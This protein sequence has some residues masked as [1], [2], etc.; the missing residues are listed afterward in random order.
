[1]SEGVVVTLGGSRELSPMQRGLWASQL[2]TPGAPVQN[3]VLVSHIDGPVDPERLA[4]AFRTVVEASDVLRTRLDRATGAVQLIPASDVP[5]SEILQLGREAVDEW[6][7]RR[8]RTTIDMTHCGYDS[9]I[10]LHPDGTV[11]WYLS[12]HH[13]VTDAVSSALVFEATADAYEGTAPDLTSYYRWARQLSGHRN[14]GEPVHDKR[15]RRAEQH[16]QNR[17]AAP[18]LSGLYRPIVDAAPDA[19][20][21]PLDLGPTLVAKAEARLA[22]DYRMLTDALGWTAL[23]VTATAAYCHRLTGEATFSIGLPMHNRSDP[24]SRALVGPT[25]EVFPVDVRIEP[26]DTYRTLHK[27]LSRAMLTTMAHAAPGTSPTPDYQVVVNAIGRPAQQRFGRWPAARRWVHTDAIDASHLLRVQMTSYED[28]IGGGEQQFALDLNNATAPP[29]D[30]ARATGHYLAVLSDLIDEPDAPIGDTVLCDARELAELEQW[31]RGADAVVTPSLVAERLRAALAGRTSP[32]LDGPGAALSG[33]ELWQWIEATAAWLQERG[34]GRGT[35]VGVELPR[36]PEAVVAIMGTLLAGGSFVPIDPAQPEARRSSLA[37]RAGCHL[38]VDAAAGVDALRTDDTQ[39]PLKPVEVGPGD[40]AYLLFTSGS[41]GQPKGVPITH[42]GLAGYL[43]FALDEYVTDGR[44]VVAPLFSALTFDLTITTLFVP[45]L[46]GGSLVVIEDDGPQALTAIAARTDITWCKATPSHLRLLVRMLPGDHRLQTLVVGGEAFGSGLA[47]E[48]LDTNPDM[49]VH[50][51]YGPTEAVVGCMEYQV[52][53]DLLATQ[54]EVPIGRPAPGVTLLTLDRYQQRLPMGASGE[55]YIA[56]DGLTAGYLDSDEND[57]DSPFVQVDGRRF[58]RS[59]DLVRLQDRQR[60]VYLGRIDEQVK[61][62]GIRLEPVEVEAALE[63]HPLVERAAVRLWSP[64]ATTPGQHCIRCGL[65]DNVPGIDFDDA[66]V[67]ST[68]HSFDRVAPVA[69]SWFRTP[70]DLSAKL[71]EV[72]SRATGDYDCLHLLSGGKDST[73]ALYRLVELGFRPYALTLDNGFISDGAKENVRRSV[74]DLQIDH[75]FATSDAMNDIFRDSLERFSNVC[76]GCY[77]TIYT[78]ATTRAVELGIPLII[79]G[80]SRGQLFE[81]RLV[82]QQFSIDRFDPDAID[83]AVLEARKTYH[84]IDDGPNRLLD[85][86][87]FADDAVFEQVEYL[88]FYRYMDVELAD[89]LSFLTTR[90]PWVRPADTGRSTNCLINAAGIHTHQTE[91]GFHNYAEPYAWDVRL[92]HKTRTEAIEELDDQLDLGDVAQMLGEVGYEPSPRRIL[93][94]WVELAGSADEMP[95]PTE[96]RAFLGQRLPTHAIPSAFMAVDALPLT[97]N[98]KLD[99]AALP[100]PRRVHRPSSELALAPTTEL[101]RTIVDLWERVLRVEPI[102]VDDDF[103]ALGGDSLAALGMIVALA[104]ARGRHLGEDLAFVHT[105]PRALAAAVELHEDTAGGPGPE[106]PDQLDLASFAT[107]HGQAPTPSAGELAILFDQAERP[108]DAMYN[109]A[110][111]YRVHGPVDTGRFESAL[112]TVAARHQPLTWAHGAPRRELSSREAVRFEAPT[113][114]LDAADVEQASSRLHREPYDLENG[115]LL[116]CLVQPVDDGSTVVFLGIHHV[117]GDA[118]SIDRLWRQVDDE[119]S[120]RPAATLRTDYAGFAAW[121][122]ASLSDT[123]RD[124]W[125]AAAGDQPPARLAIHPPTTPEPDGYLTRTASVS[126]DQLRLATRSSRFAVVLAAVAAVLR[127]HSDGPE[128]EIGMIASTRDRAEADDLVGYFLNTVP[129]RLDCDAAPSMAALVDATAATV[130]GALAHRSYPLAQLRADRRAAGLAEPVT[131][132]MVALQDFDDVR[133][134]GQRVEQQVF[135][136]GTAVSDITFFI[137]ARG[138]QL[139]LALEHRGSRV[140]AAVAERL[141]SRFDHALTSA[142]TDASAS[143]RLWDAE[144]ATDGLAMGADLADATLAIDQIAAHL[145]RRSEEPAVV[146]GS[147]SISWRT[148]DARVRSIAAGLRAR[149]VA[150]GDRVVVC[151]PRSTDLVAAA[152]AV[153][154]VGASY[155]PVDPG[156]PAGR[157]RLIV[158]A[159]GAEV[160][161]VSEAA[162]ALVTQPMLLSHLGEGPPPSDGR[163]VVSARPDHEA[164]VIFTSGSTGRPRGV[165]VRHHNLAAS[166]N[167]RAQFYDDQPARFLVVSSPAFDSSIVGLFWTLATGGTVVL[168]TEHEVHDVD[169]LGDLLTGGSLTHTLMVPS[170]HQA[171]LNRTSARH[172]G[173][174]VAWA[175]HVIVAGEACPPALVDE[176]AQLLPSVALTN[177]Y[178]PTEATVWA[179][180]HRCL[181]GASVVPIGRPIAGS[182]AAVVDTVGHPVPSGVEG[183]LVIGGLGVVDGY[184]DDPDATAVKF[185]SLDIALPLPPVGGLRHFRTGDRAVLIDGVARFLGRVDNQLNVGGARVEPEEIEAVLAGVDGVAAVIVSAVDTRPLADL[186]DA[187]PAAAVARAMQDAATRPDPAQAFQAELRAHGSADLRIVAHL[188]AS[189]SLDVDTV[190]RHAARSLPR[191]LQPALYARHDALPRT[192]N[193]KIDRDAT[194]LLALPAPASQVTVAPRDEAADS[195]LTD[196]LTDLFRQVLR[197]A[198]I[199]PDDSFFDR[200]GQS[201]LAME[202]LLSAEERLGRRLS[203]GML[204]DHPT[205]GDLAIALGD[206]AP[207]ASAARS[208]LVPIQP[209]GTQPPMF[210]VHVL[211][212]DC[213]FF[214][215]L[216]A[217]LGE[218][219][220]LFGLGQPTATPDADAPSDISDIAAVYADEIER[221]APDGPVSLTAISL[222]GTVAFELAQQLEARGRRVGLL[223]L[224]DSAGPEGSLGSISPAKR[225]AI[226]AQLF[227]RTGWR[228]ASERLQW[229]R[230]RARR[231]RQ[232][233]Q[234]QFQERLHLEPNQDLRIRQFIETNIQTQVA[235]R[236]EPYL[237]PMLV[238]RAADSPFV[239]EAYDET[240]GWSGVA[241]GSLRVESVPGGH[242]TM[243]SEPYVQRVAEVM[244]DALSDVYGPSGGEAVGAV[245]RA[246]VERAL[247]AGLRAGN[248]PSVVA[249]L[250]RRDDLDADAEQLLAACD[251]VTV[252]LANST[253]QLAQQ[254]EAA[255]GEAGLDARLRPGPKRLQHASAAI[256]VTG[257]VEA[258]TAA[259]AEL[260][261][262]VDEGIGVAARRAMVEGGGWIDFVRRDVATTRLRLGWATGGVGTPPSGLSGRVRGAL[263]PSRADFLAAELPAWAWRAYWPLRPARVARDRLRRRLAGG[264]PAGGDLGLFLGTP[265]GLIAPLLRFAEVRP[266]ELVVDLGCGDGR[267]LIEAAR[268]FGCRGRGYETDERLAATARAA[269]AAAGLEDKIE[270]LSADAAGADLASV[271]LVFAFLPPESV[272]ALLEPALARLA[273]GARMLTHEQLGFPWPKAPDRTQLLVSDPEAP[274]GAGGITVANLWFGV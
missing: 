115:P 61:V 17:P 160:G 256:S 53:P 158:D 135:W 170:L 5:G 166:T 45:L 97:T 186:L 3:M 84:R 240:F 85:T 47:R 206:T 218:D 143:P 7:R 228:Y 267:I 174:E 200:G 184:L 48:L 239:D 16:W 37:S 140:G 28:E 148:L 87:V 90:A 13:V 60:M 273:P 124:H 68:C 69:G 64:S 260:G 27:R 91:R 89:M 102:S 259:M 131:D 52:E 10:V 18:K 230:L 109:I 169:A 103:F 51:E 234:L 241:A 255:L 271:D 74:A 59:G 261:F 209:N 251:R 245:D 19:E 141:L 112:R 150:P 20:R 229:Q 155:V 42:G 196:T 258:A 49:V 77:K 24:D 11:S 80:L 30:R 26:G 21:L 191:P 202:F 187:L 129:I 161:I 8:A 215:P 211:G 132:V 157:I 110:R 274:P 205:P 133:L 243:T 257:D 54:S 14:G 156:Y 4:A 100:A 219:Q 152:V 145:D 173:T 75:E 134:E 144:L 66:G 79:T 88:D 38:I 23:L 63:S 95:T 108:D 123:A 189:S 207:A 194:G 104:E 139:T 197:D 50:N 198:D 193:G 265:Q 15:T 254:A 57:P 117:S 250:G 65:P 35:R 252:G 94:A 237:S 180:A 168:P 224:L 235:Y 121:Q 1:M 178:G 127:S 232:R 44:P 262:E 223:T 113:A 214:R 46:A 70:D 81:T 242:I 185:A 126:V 101:E 153:H 192:P 9:A 128:V 182:W 73:Y 67:C 233:V 221:V 43:Q 225:L 105:T 183:E 12:L 179:T 83:R 116:R 208:F 96:F 244:A 72:R 32:A 142:V 268:A 181:P 159:S 33:D 176:H 195:S 111:L 118:E 238:L 226:H 212:V 204:Y 119:L 76:H 266:D 136:N 138:D 146:C 190:R 163:L 71:E 56:H 120:G 25:L 22:D 272:G 78:L 165:P 149:G 55:L 122:R 106:R 217:R 137:T 269:V 201:L 6:A 177:E 249:V 36:S 253:E 41:T 210:A 125:L 199:G 222:G 29:V 40:E 216:A 2:A 34:V 151:L 130:G 270:I 264:P 247:A 31:E 236:F 213:E 86:E 175:D 162:E 164:Y 171:L 114:V 92:G 263:Q 248:L 167:A 39:R 220:P 188:E 93:T 231:L 82:P 107:P 203:V 99:E 62:G 172:P 246:D 98:G 147:A 58:Y 227:R 154:T